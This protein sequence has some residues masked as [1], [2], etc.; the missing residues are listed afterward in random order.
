MAAPSKTFLFIFLPALFLLSCRGDHM[1]ATRRPGVRY[2]AN[3]P[4]SSTLYNK[5]YG[6]VDYSRAQGS[7]A[8]RQDHLRHRRTGLHQEEDRVDAG[9]GAAAAAA[10][11]RAAIG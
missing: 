3:T 7:P 1:R 10:D 9:S 11:Q 6:F 5:G 2:C 4:F 8:P